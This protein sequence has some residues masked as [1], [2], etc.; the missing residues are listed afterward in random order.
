MPRE[1]SQR[2]ATREHVTDR[3]LALCASRDR[4]GVGRT[5]RPGAIR[6]GIETRHDIAV[7][8]GPQGIVTIGRAA[9]D[10]LIS[11]FTGSPAPIAAAVVRMREWGV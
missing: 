11:E 1:P 3:W 10:R 7:A 9:A 4:P 8:D 6:T 5:D 2:P